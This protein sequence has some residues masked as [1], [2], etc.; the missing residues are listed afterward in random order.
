MQTDLLIARNP[1]PESRLAY[2]MRLPLGEGM[3]LR[4]AGTWPREK[5]LFCYPVS[6][7]EWPDDPD[8][9]EQVPVRSCVRRGAAI[10]LV[11]N[12]ARENRSQIVFTTARGRQAVFWQS[13]RTR[14]QARPKVTT[15]TA[16]AAGIPDLEILVDTRER[17]AYRFAQQQVATVKKALSCG[18]YAVTIDDTVVAAVER[19]SL[20]DLVSSLINGTLRYALGSCP[21][22]PARPSWSGS[23]TPRSSNSTGSARPSWPTVS[24]SCR[25][26]GRMCRSCSARPGSSPRSGPTATSPPRTPGPTPRPRQS[27]ASVAVL[28][29]TLPLRLYRLH[30]LPPLGRTL[31]HR[32]HVNYVPGRWQTVTA[33]PTAVGCD[34]RSSPPGAPHIRGN[35][36]VATRLAVSRRGVTSE[37]SRA[38][39]SSLRDI[40]P[41]VRPA[42]R[43]GLWTIR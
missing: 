11:L 34:R 8:I 26:A 13:P 25:S 43:R 31:P 22:C 12:R 3:V 24:L 10:D 40:S 42:A 7:Q 41:V 18:D 4:T 15:P 21:R 33:C 14:K 28:L 27:S 17:Y 29:T 20:P 32:V 5:A 9:V 39:R 6:L 37:G 2:L 35:G 30:L 1:D 19:K 36:T 23:A 38:D 16:R